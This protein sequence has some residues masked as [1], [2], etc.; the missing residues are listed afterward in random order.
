M[1]KRTVE[2]DRKAR[3]EEMRRAEQAAERRRTLLVMGAA[4][5][6]VAVLVGLVVTTV[7]RY[8]RD[9]SLD[10]VGVPVADAGCGDV[11]TEPSQGTN[12][13][14]DTPVDYTSVPPMFGAH[15]PAPEFPASSFYTVEDR[16]ELETLVHNLEHGYTILWYSEDLPEDQVEAVERIAGLARDESA[17]GGKFIATAWDPAR[18]ELPA[19]TPVALTHWGASEGAR[20]Y[21]GAVSGAAVQEFVDAH[22][23]SDSPEPNAQ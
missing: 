5:V 8:T 11:T 2:K 16:P 6:V 20:Q 19:D 7:V 15:R 4:L 17:A 23:A 9:N 21:C 14:V 13:H 10:A 1:G 3:V 22:P 12:E 18:G